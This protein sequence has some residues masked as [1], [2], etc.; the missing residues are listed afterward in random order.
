[1]TRW[2]NRNLDL[3]TTYWRVSVTILIAFNFL[4]VLH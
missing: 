3:R 4:S 2:M 1:M